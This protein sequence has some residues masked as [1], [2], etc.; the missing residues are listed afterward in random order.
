MR[1]Y[2]DDGS[3]ARQLPG[4]LQMART[5]LALLCI[6]PQLSLSVRHPYMTFLM[7]SACITIT[8][9]LLAGCGGDRPVSPTTPL[10][11][12]WDAIAFVRTS[13]P[14]ILRRTWTLVIAD[15]TGR[16]EHVLTDTL[17]DLFNGADFA[18]DGAKL[19]F[20]GSANSRFQDS[21][22]MAARPPGLWLINRDGTGL[23][24][25]YTGTAIFPRWSPDGKQIVFTNRGNWIVNAD[26]SD[27]R[28]LPNTQPP[29]IQPAISPDGKL[30]AFNRLAEPSTTSAALYVMGI[31]G[32]NV[33]LLA[34]PTSFYQTPSW[35]PDSRRVAFAQQFRIMVVSVDGG[36]PTELV[37]GAPMGS[38]SF[39][40]RSDGSAVIVS[41]Y[42]TCCNSYVSIYRG[43][44][45]DGAWVS[46]TAPTPTVLEDFP[47]WGLKR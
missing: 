9:V 47:S 30:V 34:P 38:R 5:A 14:N 19:V 15:T 28:A 29:D 46:L 36:N 44:L 21:A 11:H 8:G 40:W 23:T 42:A 17:W 39:A 27:A 13:Q 32:S 25:I 7:K 6:R 35:S 12:Q 3:R 26:G 45:A 22:L 2:R 31:D 18:P 33:R 41:Q 20:A 1:R 4:E 37:P 10:S 16:N 43:S 24:R